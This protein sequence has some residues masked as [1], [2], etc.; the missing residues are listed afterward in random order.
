MKVT[1]T[2]TLVAVVAMLSSVAL[3][4]VLSPMARIVLA[5]QSEC[6]TSSQ[7]NALDGA[8]SEALSPDVDIYI[9]TANVESTIKTVQRLGG[10]VGAVVDGMMTATVLSSQIDSLARCEGVTK[11]DIARPLSLANDSVRQCIRIN[12]VHTGLGLPQAYDGTGVIYGTFDRGIN[13]RHAEF[14]DANMQTRIKRVYLATDTTGH[15]VWGRVYSDSTVAENV[16]FP[17]SEF[18][19]EEIDTLTTDYMGMTHGTHTLGTGTGS[20]RGN[21]YYGCAP[22]CDIIACGSAKEANDAKILNAVSYIFQKADEWTQPCVVNLSY[23]SNLGPHDGTSFFCRML[24]S[25]IGEGRI[26]VLSAGNQGMRTNHLSK[27]SSLDSVRTFVK[28]SNSGSYQTLNEANGYVSIY[29]YEKEHP[30]TTQVCVYDNVNKRVVFRSQTVVSN[31]T[32]ATAL[33]SDDNEEFAKYFTGKVVTTSDSSQKGY[34]T[35]LKIDMTATSENYMLGLVVSGT[36]RVELYSN[37][38]RLM[39]DNH[40]EDGWSKGTA[41]G[42][43]SDMATGNKSISVGA[44]TSKN[45]VPYLDGNSKNFN[46]SEYGDI[47]YFSSYGPD[48]NG[49][50]KPDVTAPGYVVVSGKSQCDGKY[51]SDGSVAVA[52]IDG[53]AS[54]WG[55]EWGTSMAAPA[56]AGTIATWLQVNPKLTPEQIK[57]ILNETSK[58]DEWVN[59]YPQKW[60]AGKLDAYAGI[61]YVIEQSGISTIEQDQKTPLKAYYDRSSDE[62]KV[63][64]EEVFSV[65]DLQGRNVRNGSLD[66]GVYLVV[67]AK[68]RSVK[69][70]VIKD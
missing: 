10:Q 52:E 65:Y 42:S 6:S 27:P 40:D 25:M 64:P 20:Y 48:A 5:E 14:K 17:G 22:G 32:T 28:N 18:Y 70:P 8:V 2:L 53:F 15:E 29:S 57:T 36:T 33:R 7:V 39:F 67:T 45:K 1:K 63:T 49:V 16:R 51:S 3:A 69:V 30:F 43:I 11:I 61:K 31:D 24:D 13:F 23:E 47:A 59:L 66:S 50:A 37:A 26:V 54:A 34:E 58:R 41:D 21:P 35:V 19:G 56:V 68:G 12:D 9:S 38:S 62:I 60:G 55:V 4:G 46:A 44:W